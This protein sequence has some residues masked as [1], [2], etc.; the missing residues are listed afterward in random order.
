MKKFPYGKHGQWTIQVESFKLTPGF[1]SAR[2]YL[3]TIDLDELPKIVKA[4]KAAMRKEGVKPGKAFITTVP[5][6]GL[7]IEIQS[8]R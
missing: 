4:M 1:G 2:I 6:K 5:Y 8:P 3:G 7:K